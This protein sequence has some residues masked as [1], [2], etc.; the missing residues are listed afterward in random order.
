MTCNS[1]FELFGYCSQEFRSVVD[2]WNAVGVDVSVDAV[3]ETLN[4]TETLQNGTHKYYYAI[5]NITSTSIIQDSASAIYESS[6]SIVLAPGF[7]AEYGS[8]VLART[9]PCDV[10]NNNRMQSNVR[11]SRIREHS[12]SQEEPINYISIS[13]NPAKEKLVI[14]GLYNYC[15]YI[16]YDAMGRI[17]KMGILYYPYHIDVAQLLQGTYILKVTSDN[18]NS[19]IKFLKQ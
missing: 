18:V 12:S 19:Y 5:S 11:Y 7:R 10:A 3:Q 16:I 1:A 13:P 17:E 15:T 9:I 6:G 4:I 14:E 8:F 2:A